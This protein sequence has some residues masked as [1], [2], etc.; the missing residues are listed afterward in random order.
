[1]R[2]LQQGMAIRDGEPIIEARNLTK[3]FRTYRTG[4]GMLGAL[5]GLFKRTPTDTVAVDSM[6]F[7]ISEGEVVGYIGANGAGKS[8]TIKMLTGILLPTSGEV[9]VNGFSPH[10]ERRRYVRG[11]GVVFGQRT[12]LW[13][14]LAPIESFR[15]LSRIYEIPRGEFQ[16]RLD[17]MI[18]LLEMKDFL[19]TPVRKL[20]LGQ[21]MRCDLAAALLHRPRILFLDEPTIGLDVLGKTRVRDFLKSINLRE[22]ITVL[23]TTHDLE[24]I[25]RLCDRIII[26]DKGQKVF[27]GR[28][29][30]LLQEYAPYKR[31]IVDF[32]VDPDPARYGDLRQ[33]G[34]EFRRLEEYRGEFSF[35][36]RVTSS[37]ETIQVVMARGTVRDVRIEEP[38]IED[39]V[40]AIYGHGTGSA[41]RAQFKLET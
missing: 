24:E 9:R 18:E 17:E 30:D 2:R 21:R 34:I 29:A 41:N 14:D 40:K 19:Q 20:S 1:M 7:E 33:R 13:W 5:R 37:A 10:R 12:Q 36:R 6:N 3:V 8:T 28:L 26:I 22:R 38:G 39:V 25:E 31:L 16:G 15:L 4:E 11:I 32:D 23:L 35:D 27:D